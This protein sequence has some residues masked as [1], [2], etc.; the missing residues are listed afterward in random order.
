M[1]SGIR[2]KLCLVCQ[3]R[4]RHMSEYT[5]I[6]TTAIYKGEA[7]RFAKFIFAK[8]LKPLL[9]KPAG[10]GLSGENLNFAASRKRLV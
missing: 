6:D 3:T 7:V 9:E 8:W 4:C 1:V 5:L 10:S 2:G